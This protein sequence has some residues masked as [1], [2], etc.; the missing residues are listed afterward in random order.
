VEEREGAS[1]ESEDVIT[2]SRMWFLSCVGKSTC[3]VRL[4][5]DRSDRN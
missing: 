1:E 4:K 3:W 2:K 5:V